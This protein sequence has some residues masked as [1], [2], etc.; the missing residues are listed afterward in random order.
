MHFRFVIEIE[1]HNL[2][3]QLCKYILSFEHRHDG[4]H[5]TEE[6]TLVFESGLSKKSIMFCLKPNF[7]LDHEFYHVSAILLL[8]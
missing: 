4:T 1:N 6:E 5:D 7:L 2:Y 8:T 3:M